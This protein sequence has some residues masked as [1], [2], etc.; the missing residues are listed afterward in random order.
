VHALGWLLIRAIDR[1]LFEDRLVVG[2]GCDSTE[3]ESILLIDIIEM[4]VK[5]GIKSGNG[6]GNSKPP[7]VLVV[8]VV[9]AC[10]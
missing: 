8:V 10:C 3:S 4:L 2:E 6:N 9:R 1:A 7:M 5:N